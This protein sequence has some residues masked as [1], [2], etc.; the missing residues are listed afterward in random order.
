MSSV[1]DKHPDG[2]VD[3][4]HRELHTAEP[5]NPANPNA[6]GQA[7]VLIE[8]FERS[9]KGAAKA[10]KPSIRVQLRPASKNSTN[11]GA[12]EVPLSPAESKVT[13]SRSIASTATSR[14]SK[15]SR[16]SRTRNPTDTA[17]SI[18][19][20]RSELTDHELDLLRNLSMRTSHTARSARS[21]TS[22]GTTSSQLSAVDPDLLDSIIANVIRRLVLPELD[23]IKAST[24]Q[25]F[26]ETQSQ[27]GSPQ[28]S[29]IMTKLPG[30]PADPDV[31]PALDR[32]DLPTVR[33][34]QDPD[35]AVLKQMFRSSIGT[36]PRLRAD[37]VST[38]GGA[39]PLPTTAPL[40]VGTEVPLFPS[41]SQSSLSSAG[42]NIASTIKRS[43]SDNTLRSQ[44]KNKRISPVSST[45]SRHTSTQA[46]SPRT[47]Q[48]VRSFDKSNTNLDL[49][50]SNSTLQ[51][52]LPISG[53]SQQHDRK[54][55]E[56]SFVGGPDQLSPEP[57]ATPLAL[58]G[59][60][61]IDNS[62][63][64]QNTIVHRPS[65]QTPTAPAIS[66][67]SAT[68]P[69]QLSDGLGIHIPQTD[70]AAR[71]LWPNNNSRLDVAPDALTDD[72]TS[73]VV[74]RQGYY[75]P[76]Q[77][78]SDITS[79]SVP[80][81]AIATLPANEQTVAVQSEPGSKVEQITNDYLA[82]LIGRVL[83][84][85]QRNAER[86]DEMIQHFGFLAQEMQ[87]R[88]SDMRENLQRFIVEGNQHS[89]G[90]VNKHT[91]REVNRLR[92]PRPYGGG[93]ILD[94]SAA[95][96]AAPPEKKTIIQK[97]LS[98]MRTKND[99]QKV[100]SLLHEILAQVEN[101]NYHQSTMATARAQSSSRPAVHFEPERESRH[102]RPVKR[103]PIAPILEQE[104]PLM[105]QQP[106]SPIAV[107]QAQD[108]LPV[109]KRQTIDRDLASEDRTVSVRASEFRNMTPLQQRAELER[110]DHEKR[111][112]EL[113]LNLQHQQ[114]RQEEDLNMTPVDATVRSFAPLPPL[115]E[116]AEESS[117]VRGI[118][119][120]HPVGATSQRQLDV[121]PGLPHLKLTTASGH[122]TNPSQDSMRTRMTET[123]PQQNTLV[124]EAITAQ[125]K[126]SPLRQMF[127]KLGADKLNFSMSGGSRR[128]ASNPISST[129]YY[130]QPNSVPAEQEHEYQ[131]EPTQQT[132]R[133]APYFN[134]PLMGR[135]NNSSAER[136][137]Y[138]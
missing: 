94:R 32:R 101:T 90:E 71:S 97:A 116:I 109:A 3:A 46:T 113:E 134:L 74:S 37:S 81:A 35:S 39:T 50:I 33:P 64:S 112:R 79:A 57:P 8:Y 76:R 133:R 98:S 102:S 62:L 104:E 92:G 132:E 45:E 88:L 21:R 7:S 78:P 118:D 108:M 125:K 49:N 70:T 1:A 105:E 126:T 137:K 65:T 2:L 27:Q 67:E 77:A 41:N 138:M 115:Q 110:Q 9:T 75:T 111:W 122:E 20:V 120:Y 72:N 44:H 40:Q 130:S 25:Q 24:S 136:A 36:P 61:S 84:N 4:Y 82:S 128:S 63:S 135:Y 96:A 31:S 26:R 17:S 58:N 55:S 53:G 87:A 73:S 43:S 123:P 34:P 66:H 47:P 86:H 42:A 60:L 15:G 11:T 117:S 69:Q 119:I 28:S 107:Q 54:P 106:V 13:A 6:A 91:T 19:N 129:E 100:E 99:L 10:Q 124:P 12:M 68:V 114:Q 29:P 95:T 83:Q 30:L 52:A 14:K 18:V 59:G 22:D 85:D 16:T 121:R 56:F 131:P 103:V 80:P 89:I 93:T 48:R 38:V 127:N 5:S 51:P 23:S